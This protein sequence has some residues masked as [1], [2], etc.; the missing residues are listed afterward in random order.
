[1]F[2]LGADDPC[3]PAMSLGN[4]FDNKQSQTAAF[5]LFMFLPR[6]AYVA[7]KKVFLI[8]WADAKPGILNTDANLFVMFGYV[9]FNAAAIRGVFDGVVHKVDDRAF[10]H[11]DIGVNHR[12]IVT[13]ADREGNLLLFS[14]DKLC[15]TDAP[16]NLAQITL[17]TRDFVEASFRV[18]APGILNVIY[19]RS[20]LTAAGKDF[21][22][23]VLLFFIQFAHQ[24][25]FQHV[26][27]ALHGG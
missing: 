9:H 12:D 1:A 26:G 20:H 14:R 22:D 24:P 13:D 5:N 27:K 18:I 4:T 15:I 21:S 17:R 10:Q 8:L 6:D 2:A 19:Q 16:D 23:Q 25:K 3:I 7:L 11:I